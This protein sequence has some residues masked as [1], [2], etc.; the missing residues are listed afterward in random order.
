MGTALT[1]GSYVRIEMNFRVH[2]VQRI[3]ELVVGWRKKL[4]HLVSTV[5]EQKEFMIGIK[6][7]KVSIFIMA[8]V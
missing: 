1:P 5:C 7:N 3:R 8:H 6:K 2:S 4:T